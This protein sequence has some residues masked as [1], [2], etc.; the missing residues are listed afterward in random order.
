MARE[1]STVS[2]GRHDEHKVQLIPFSL[3][4]FLPT[5]WNGEIRSSFSD[6]TEQGRGEE[7]FRNS[8]VGRFIPQR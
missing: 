2:M 4:S 3:P 8:Q 6:L 7:C 5:N 1:T